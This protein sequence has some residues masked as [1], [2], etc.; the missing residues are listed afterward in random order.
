MANRTRIAVLGMLHAGPRSGYDL[1]KAFDQQVRHFWAE[2]PGQIYPALRALEDERLVR[3]KSGVRN[4]RTRTVYSISASGRRA[5]A[6]WMAETPALPVVRN[7]VLLKVFFGTA[8]SPDVLLEHVEAIELSMRGAR[9]QYGE[10]GRQ[11][12]ELADSPEQEILWKLTLS[13]GRRT[14]EARLD[15]CQEAKRTLRKLVEGKVR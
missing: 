9:A 14:V 11:I 13:S 15:W 4:G 6:E 2:S 1:K 3:S 8:T 5:F 10:F 7:E 12:E